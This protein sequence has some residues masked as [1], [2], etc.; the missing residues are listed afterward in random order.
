MIKQYTPR[1]ETLRFRR[2]S[3]KAY[4]AFVSICKLVTIGCLKREIA[5]QSL[6]KN[7]SVCIFSPAIVEQEEKDDFCREDELTVVAMLCQQNLL[8]P[9]QVK[10]V[11]APQNKIQY[12]NLRQRAESIWLTTYTFRSFCFSEIK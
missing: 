7:I 10:S 12:N 6:A 8:L 2:W 1:T 9:V 5:E 4:A 3:R 11:A